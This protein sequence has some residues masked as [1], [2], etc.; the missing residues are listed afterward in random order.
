M[1]QFVDRLLSDDFLWQTIN[2]N[3]AGRRKVSN[4]FININCPMCVSRGESAD[5][6]TRCGIKN[7]PDRSIGIFCFNCGFKTKWTPGETLGRGM[8][9]FLANIGVPDDEIKRINHRALTYR[10]MIEQ[11]PEAA[12]IIPDYFV[13]S[14]KPIRLPSGAKTFREWM[15]EGCT[16]DNFYSAVNY[17]EG[18]GNDIAGNTFYWTPNE[19]DGMHKR[20]IIPCYH[21]GRIVGY[22]MR[23]CSPDIAPRYLKSLPDNYLFNVDTMKNK[24]REITIIVEGIFDA[25]AISGVGLLGS[26]INKEQAQWLSQYGKTLIYL[27]DRDKKGM[28]SIDYALE[29]G[30]GVSFPFIKN[31]WWEDDIKDAADAVKKY[32]RLYTLISIVKSAVFN[33][34]EINVKRRLV[35]I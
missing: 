30:W 8:R 7:N 9:E 14:F 6:K 27:P 17:I 13:P 11:S 19:R 24:R 34:L 22:T 31:D 3:L 33:P 35:T 15:E 28:K 25:L 2:A 32:G 29:Y 10:S 20:V 4:G 5:K 21:E 18:R 26:T 23:S 16:D 1:N 12:D